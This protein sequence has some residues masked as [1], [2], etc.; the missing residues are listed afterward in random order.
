MNIYFSD[1]KLPNDLGKSIFLAGPTPRSVKVASWRPEACEILEDL[2]FDGNV[3]VPEWSSY[4]SRTDYLTQV[5][6]EWKGLQECSVIVV[7]VPRELKTMPAFTTN[8]EFATYIRDE[9]MVYGRPD[10]AV[11]CEYLDWLYG[12]FGR[13]KPYNKL[14]D[15]LRKAVEKAG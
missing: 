14:E 2:G 12:K 13:G 1:D 3:L 11:K 6:W 5:E 15:I 8:C 7:W 9:R 4:E 10:T